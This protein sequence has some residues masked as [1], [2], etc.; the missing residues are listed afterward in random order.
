MILMLVAVATGAFAQT[1]AN[2][3]L[4]TAQMAL[5]SAEAAGAATLAPVLY[6]EARWRVAS[7]QENWN[8]AKQNTRDQARMRAK[9][10]LWAARA[11]SAKAQWLGTN[12]AIR[13]LQTDINRF[14]GKS[15]VKLPEESPTLALN[16][17]ATSKERVAYAQAAIDQAKAAGAASVVGGELDD[18]AKS[19]ETARKIVK[20]A[21]NS[22]SADHVAY[23]AEMMARRAYYLVRAQ[24]ARR[25]LPAMQSERTRFALAESERQAA[26]ER[27]RNEQARR[28]A[29]A[30]QQALEQEQAN[31]RAEAEE[32]TRLRAQVDENRRMMEARLEENRA[33]RVQ[34]EQ[35]LD[36]VM[37][38][39]ESA[40]IRSSPNE[41]EA[42][43]R[44]VEDQ[45]IALRAMQAREQLDTQ[46][47]NTEIERLNG[48]LDSARR[49]GNVSAQLL[50]E[51]EAEIARRKEQLEAMTREREQSIARAQEIETRHQAAIN[52]AQARRQEA[53]AAQQQLKQQADAARQQAAQAQAEAQA[54][55]AQA[56]SARQ[57]AERARRDLETARTEMQAR[58]ASRVQMET[59]LAKLAATRRDARGL[60]VTLPGIFFDT[61]KS[62]IKA[63]SKKTLDR[64]ATQLNTD[65]NIRV[66]V[67]GH[68]DSVGSDVSNQKLSEAR[69]NAVREYLVSKGVPDASITS[70]GLGEAQPVASNKT[71]SGRQQNR[72]VELVINN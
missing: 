37:R 43:R 28:D 26:A 24:D 65:R 46:S 44:Q 63:A 71:A 9:E 39:Y 54:A 5:Q 20:G 6:E 17:G 4:N 11:A 41:V 45:Q 36:A 35:R 2:E 3:A 33:A 64:I 61:G 16:R 25:T 52:E 70:T 56:E 59:E 55:Q 57:D 21:S 10:A 7:A 13:D 18:A 50:S 15:D 66:V 34:A 72:R 14:G 51:R 32:L 19:L 30:A 42:L 48:Q 67:E 69:A 29:I 22:E 8:A 40:I 12:A 31:R 49:E 60:I 38:E 58:E 1:A 62:E 68:T 23:V 47:M 53:E 27:A